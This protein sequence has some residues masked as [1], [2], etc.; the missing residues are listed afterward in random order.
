MEW[1]VFDLLEEKID[2]LI[3]QVQTFSQENQELKRKLSEQT[4]VVAQAR[5]QM[6]ALEEEK[7]LVRGK[8]DGILQKIDK[9][10]D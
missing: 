4:Q 1:N 7:N 2:R 9:I 5:E 8:V 6:D 10:M 3:A